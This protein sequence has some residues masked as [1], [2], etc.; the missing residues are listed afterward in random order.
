M[1]WDDVLSGIV[2]ALGGGVDAW[3]MQQRAKAQQAEQER[4]R[5]KQEEDDAWRKM[6]QDR[7]Q[8]D[9]EQENVR[10]VVDDMMPGDRVD[11]TLAGRMR[12]S[13]MGHRI[14]EMPEFESSVFSSGGP[15]MPGLPGARTMQGLPD[16]QMQARLAPT[17]KERLAQQAA[18]KAAR[19][20]AE[21]EARLDE[22]M[23]GL[24]VPARLAIQTGRLTGKMPTLGPDDTLTADE[25]IEQ[26]VK[27]GN[28]I[29]P[30][31]LKESI[32]DAKVRRDFSPPKDDAAPMLTPQGLDIAAHQFAT[33]G[34]LPPMGMGA[35]AAQTR[36]AIINRAA[37]LFP[38][39]NIAGNRAGYE[40]NRGSLVKLQ[41]QRDAVGAFEQTALKNMD[42]FLEAAGKV[43]DTGSPMANRV[44]R[45]VSGQMVG[46]ENQAAYDAARAVLIPE[47][48][49]IVTNPNLTSVLSDSAR[50]EVAK[51]NPENATLAQTVRVMRLLKR[52]MQ[53]RT[54]SLDEQ[55][56]TTQGR[57]GQTPGA[58]TATS[59]AG[60]DDVQYERVN[61]KLVRKR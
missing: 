58:G 17:A 14:E 59:G 43:V 7:L 33:N 26:K 57:L 1:A 34:Q 35:K 61:G 38:N 18:A 48:A 23:R 49:R 8:R 11:P 41:A 42:V 53:N 45:A 30:V 51:F 20:I 22:F 24:P 37:E 47:I 29:L 56:A 6:T 3:E 32:Q 19:E 4:L 36:A 2:G 60:G 28:A 54:E 44:A 31:K 10:R 13:D 12:Q 55:I 15:G 52:D 40:A 25:R 39:L 9:A 16:M 21:R 5:Q 27:E 50:E 46:S